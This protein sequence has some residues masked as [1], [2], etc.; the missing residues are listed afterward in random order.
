MSS[1][2]EKMSSALFEQLQI[3]SAVVVDWSDGKKYKCT[4]IS[5]PK[6]KSSR[7]TVLF[8][9]GSGDALVLLSRITLPTFKS[10]DSKSTKKSS[11][12]SKKSSKKSKKR[13]S[14]TTQKSKSSTKKTKAKK[15]KAI[16][17]KEQESLNVIT[18]S[19]SDSDDFV[20]VEQSSSSSSS[21]TVSEI[22]PSNTH[23]CPP[24]LSISWLTTTRFTV[25]HLAPRVGLSIVHNFSDCDYV[26][27]E[28]YTSKANTYVQ[29]YVPLGA[30]LIAI[31]HISTKNS[32]CEDV[33]TLIGTIRPVLLTFDW[34]IE[35]STKTITNKNNQK[36]RKFSNN[37]TLHNTNST[38]H[39]NACNGQ[40][41]AHT[42]GKK[43][44]SSTISESHKPLVPSVP[45]WMLA[46]HQQKSIQPFAKT[47]RTTTTTTS[48]T[49]TTTSTT[50][51]TINNNSFS[52]AS[53]SSVNAL[54]TPSY[55]QR[56]SSDD[57]DSEDED[58]IATALQ[59]MTAAN[60]LNQYSNHT[61]IFQNVI[62]EKST[63]KHLIPTIASIEISLIDPLSRGMIT[64]PCR[65]KHCDHLEVFD[66]NIFRSFHNFHKCPICN[67][68]IFEND[69]LY[70]DVD[71]LQMLHS[72]YKTSYTKNIDLIKQCHIDIHGNW[73]TDP[74]PTFIHTNTNTN[75]NTS[76]NSSSSSSSFSS[77][78]NSMNHHV[79]VIEPGR[80]RESINSQ[81]EELETNTSIAIRSYL[82]AAYSYYPHI[83]G[84]ELDTKLWR[85]IHSRYNWQE[86]I[87]MISV[88][89][90]PS[91]FKVPLAFKNYI[92]SWS[93]KEKIDF[94][95]MIS[96]RKVYIYQ[97]VVHATDPRKTMSKK[98]KRNASGIDR[99]EF[100]TLVNLPACP[101]V[102]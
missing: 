64:H 77:S 11:K 34:S 53:S 90:L 54:Q 5:K 45:L 52:A 93:L 3:N 102:Q 56:G 80:R 57:S 8:D 85:E 50:P 12:S 99:V 83:I 75:T 71:I 98:E 14:S 21:S 36:K 76:T 43:G 15:T 88:P 24:Y 46:A 10:P 29:K 31:N 79:V 61:S 26:F 39:C 78:S 69:V 22:I 59:V 18:I 89:P 17:N 40:H 84:K 47:A 19:D 101:K 38:H 28:K 32:N 1:Q 9:D 49:T 33:K 74:L 27:I 16:S 92:T 37:M 97:N 25:C 96:C 41:R 87:E 2:Q 72:V 55:N 13:S 35:T 23:T 58:D 81:Q 73:S 51:E 91:K 20:D 62:Y 48:A 70:I 4:I 65:G 100:S 7:F 67:L 66:V 95:K 30:R 60:N 94:F 68:E 86:F 44:K 42:C 82:N 63:P 6:T